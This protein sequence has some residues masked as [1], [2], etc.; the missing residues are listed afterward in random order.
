MLAAILLNLGAQTP[1]PPAVGPAFGGGPFWREY[2]YDSAYDAI[3]DQSTSTA[4]ASAPPFEFAPV[5][6]AVRRGYAPAVDY[7][8]IEARAFGSVAADMR[9]LWEV[10]LKRQKD[11]DEEIMIM[12]SLLE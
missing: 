10:E 4:L 8:S 3:R 5:A 12:L 1:A 2:G 7:E 6:Q 11:Q 9:A